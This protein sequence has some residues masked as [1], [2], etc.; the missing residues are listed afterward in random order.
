MFK[1]LY[2]YVKIRRDSKDPFLVGNLKLIYYDSI[3]K[4]KY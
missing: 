1:H 4:I 2:P 3:K